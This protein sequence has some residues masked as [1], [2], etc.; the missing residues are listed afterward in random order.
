MSDVRFLRVHARRFALYAL[1]GLASFTFAPRV[2]AQALPSGLLSTASQGVLSAFGRTVSSSS[3]A[4]KADLTIGVF[5]SG[6]RILPSRMASGL[7]DVSDAQRK[8]AREL[9]EQLLDGYDTLLEQ[10]QEAR[11]KNNVAGA[12]LYALTVGHLVLTGE[13]L[14]EGQQEGVLGSVTQALAKVQ[15]FKGL[16]DARKQEL[17]ESLVIAANLALGLQREAADHPEYEQQAKD[18]AELLYHQVL[19]R[20]HDDVTFTTSGLKFK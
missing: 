10:N 20:S 7:A 17:Y 6:A 2:H 4:A 9:Y 12:I 18:L 8:Q 13:E 16:P 14:S 15:T 5:K 3:A 19:A 1:I 11:L